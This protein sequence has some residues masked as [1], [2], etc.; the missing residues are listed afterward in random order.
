MLGVCR[1]ISSSV[2][3]HVF[4]ITVPKQWPMRLF[5]DTDLKVTGDADALLGT[6]GPAAQVISAAGR[7]QV[8]V[9]LV[10]Q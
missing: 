6:R 4:Q 3:E 10:V 7:D 5:L 2:A 8:T 1:E 9:N